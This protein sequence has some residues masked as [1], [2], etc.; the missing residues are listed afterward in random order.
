VRIRG[1]YRW[2]TPQTPAQESPALAPSASRP[3]VVMGFA[4]PSRSSKRSRRAGVP[5]SLSRPRTFRSAWQTLV[6]RSEHPPVGNSPAESSNRQPQPET[7]LQEMITA[8]GPAGGAA[9]GGRTSQA[10]PP[11]QALSALPPAATAHGS[12]P[13]T[14]QRVVLLPHAG[15]RSLTPDPPTAAQKGPPA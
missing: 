7:G 14:R 5:M 3:G 15:N 11:S 9:L 10:P 4:W 2:Y 1:Y 6:D 12:T 13:T 8:I